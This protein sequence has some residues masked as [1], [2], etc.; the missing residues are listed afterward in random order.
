MHIFDVD[1]LP[2]DM[3][4]LS[5]DLLTEIVCVLGFGLLPKGMQFWDVATEEE[6][7]SGHSPLL[8]GLVDGTACVLVDP[9]VLMTWLLIQRCLLPARAL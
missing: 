1:L 7:R 6:E 5:T 8:V 9:H 4:V 2:S 3:R